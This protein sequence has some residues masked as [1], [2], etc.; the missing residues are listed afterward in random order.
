LGVLPRAWLLPGALRP[1][2]L[3]VAAAAWSC[4]SLGVTAARSAP[5]HIGT[6][7]LAVAGLALPGAPLVVAVGLGAT[8]RGEKRPTLRLLTPACA[9][10]W[11]GLGCR[12]LVAA[13][14]ALVRVWARASAPASLPPPPGVRARVRA[15]VRAGVG[16]GLGLRSRSGLGSG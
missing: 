5:L 4:D 13:G 1:A 3:G 9:H 6:P 8:L 16:L 12:G 10:S 11:D 14:L 2:G 7:P 15:R